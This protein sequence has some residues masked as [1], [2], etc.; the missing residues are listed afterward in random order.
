VGQ[1]RI[2]SLIGAAPIAMS[3]AA[4]LLVLAVVAAQWTDDR[5][6]GGVGAHLFQLLVAGQVPIVLIYLATADW[7]RFWPIVR[8]LLFQGLAL[9]IAFGAVFF[10]K[11]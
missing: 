5:G 10:A 2:N 3:I 1:R 7:K 9:V 11:L 4:Y 8:T 6:D